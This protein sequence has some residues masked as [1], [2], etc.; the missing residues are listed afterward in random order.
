[1]DHQSTDGTDTIVQKMA[2]KG[3][4]VVLKKISEVAFDQAK[5]MTAGTNEAARSDEFDFVIPLDA[6]EFLSGPG[7]DTF[8]DF[9]SASLSP[10]QWAYMNWVTFC[11]I[12]GAYFDHANPLAT[13]FRARSHE[14][15]S[16]R[17]V[18]VGGEFAKDCKVQSGNHAVA[19]PELSVDPIQLDYAF[20][21][22]PVRSSDQIVRKILLS[23]YTFSLKAGRRPGE[24][25]HWYNMLMD[26]RN[27]NYSLSEQALVD[28]SLTYGDDISDHQVPR[29]NPDH[30]VDIDDLC[31]IEFSEL[32]RINLIKSI[33]D[34]TMALVETHVQPIAHK[35][36]KSTLKGAAQRLKSVLRG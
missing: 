15:G 1:M 30:R 31:T 29:I 13:C 22:I 9:L 19:H 21:H 8:K 11:P 17:K 6:D 26:I 35:N 27:N 20:Q 7:G 25:F 23:T 18:I 32:A 28:L 33:D 4:N 24:N 14:P 3:Y 12:S 10:D 5:H 36:H 2:D 16:F 34:F